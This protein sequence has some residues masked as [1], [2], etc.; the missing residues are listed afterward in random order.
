[1]PNPQSEPSSD[2][3]IGKNVLRAR[4]MTTQTDVAER[5]RK[6]GYKWSQSTV[7]AV[8]KGERALKLAEAQDLAIVLGVSVLELVED[9]AESSVYA[10]IRRE[11]AVA[12]RVSDQLLDVLIEWYARRERLYSTGE[13]LESEDHTRLIPE[14][15][16]SS[17][18][19]EVITFANLT[20]KDVLDTIRSSDLVIGHLDEISSSEPP[21]ED[22]EL[23]QTDQKEL[24]DDDWRQLRD[25]ENDARHHALLE[26]LF[27]VKEEDDGVDQET[28]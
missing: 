18:R 16:R 9:Q 21:P 6:L 22:L 26:H 19:Q 27:S 10:W 28:S 2:E 11:L 14:S 7:W 5:M 8:E 20:L 3:T 1:M 23:F 12:E 17:L 13:W 15:R 4:G 25:P 24:I